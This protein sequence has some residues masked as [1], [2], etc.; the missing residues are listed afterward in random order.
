MLAYLASVLYTCFSINIYFK[1]DPSKISLI[2]FGLNTVCIQVTL[3]NGQMYIEHK[4]QS[5]DTIAYRNPLFFLNQLC[6]F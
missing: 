2:H 6:A 5:S 1:N 3:H 4:Y